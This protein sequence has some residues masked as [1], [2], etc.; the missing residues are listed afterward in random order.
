MPDM[1]GYGST[2][3]PS[4][5][6]QY[7]SRCSAGGCLGQADRDV[8]DHFLLAGRGPAGNS[9]D[10]S[11]QAGNN[12][13]V[14]DLDPA[15]VLDTLASHPGL[16]AF[17]RDRMVATMPAKLSRRRLLLDAVAQAFEPGVRYPERTVDDFLRAIHPDHAALRRYLVDEGFLDRSAGTYWRVG[18]TDWRVGGT[19]PL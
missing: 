12:R 15:G 8:Y 7:V 18:G 9:S 5:A 3:R 16:R 10:V 2:A 13:A 4:I 11:A 6:P 1:A 19:G 17:V 14:S